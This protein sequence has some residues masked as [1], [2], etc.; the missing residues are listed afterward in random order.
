M[1]FLPSSGPLSINDIRNL[2]GGPGS[3]S[4][5]NYY[6]GGAYIPST[7]TVTTREPT[8]GQNFFIGTP[9]GTWYFWSVENNPN[10]GPTN[11]A[12]NSFTRVIGP[13]TFTSYT[14]GG[15]T[16]FRG[17]LVR[18]NSDPY[19]TF[20]DYGIYRESYST[21]NINTGIPSSGQISIS[22]FYGAEKP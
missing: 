10:T 15:F 20:Y 5:A 7:K 1:P 12:W 18:V 6:R 21:T 13:G 11:Y 9:V 19:G 16:Y 8:S 14:T 4:M 17:A 22:Q 3:P 2:F